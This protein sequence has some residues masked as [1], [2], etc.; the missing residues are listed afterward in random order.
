[1]GRFN[2]AEVGEHGTSG[3]DMSHSARS[4][5]EDSGNWTGDESG[6]AL[7]LA[8]G[9]PAPAA[10]MHPAFGAWQQAQ[11]EAVAQAQHNQ[12]L[13]AQLSVL[14]AAYG[15]AVPPPTSLHQVRG[16]HTQGCNVCAA[17]ASSPAASQQM[18]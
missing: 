10:P 5:R 8:S 1:M 15:L 7:A 9:A 3:E 14:R 18:Y 13:E 12:M 4:A 6:A 17:P 16:S 2:C 11:L